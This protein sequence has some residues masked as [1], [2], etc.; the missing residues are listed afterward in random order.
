MKKIDSE[1]IF[2]LDE[3]PNEMKEVPN[4]IGLYQ[5]CLMCKDYGVS[6]NGPKL[7]AL[8]DIMVVREFHRAIRVARK[9]TLKAIAD[10]AAN[11]SEYTVN[12]YFSHSVKDF[13]WTTVGAIDNALTSICGGRVGQPLSDNP[14]PAST[15]EIAEQIAAYE[16]RLEEANREI[17]RIQ[18]KY[19]RKDASHIAAMEDQRRL[20]ERMIDHLKS[21][22]QKEEDQKKDYLRR[23]DSKNRIIAALVVAAVISFLTTTAYFV[24][25]LL[26]VGVG[27]L[28]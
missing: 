20:F 23:I 8:G 21:Q 16:S 22:L 3:N 14:C 11:I 6:C 19:S 28:F 27:P 9:I 7:A 13:K 10:A 26:H 15:S 1:E 18:E 17:A 4:H 5:K 2:G 25:D 12:D 24:W